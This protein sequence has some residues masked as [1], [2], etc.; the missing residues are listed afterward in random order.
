[1]SPCNN[2]MPCCFAASWVEEFL[3][4]PFGVKGTHGTHS[5]I[6]A[7]PSPMWLAW[8]A[9]LAGTKTSRAFSRT[10]PL[11][12][13]TLLQTSLSPETRMPLLW[14][15]PCLWPVD[16]GKCPLVFCYGQRGWGCEDNVFLPRAVGQKGKKPL[17]KVT[18]PR[19]ARSSEP[20]SPSGSLS[21]SHWV[22]SS[23]HCLQPHCGCSGQEPQL[24]L[25]FVPE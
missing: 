19:G 14:E 6:L 13:Y 1:M 12:P 22:A 18:S 3:S 21:S 23:C 5:G 9:W 25:L 10:A 11:L 8:L 2:R 4:D 24:G 17:C 15:M 7:S 20:L 16:Q